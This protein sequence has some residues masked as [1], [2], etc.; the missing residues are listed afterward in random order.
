MSQRWLPVAV[1][2]AGLFAANLTA[3]LVVRLGY[4]DD[5]L[6]AD[7]ATLAMLAV[8]AVVAAGWAGVGATRHPVGRWAGDLA[9]GSLVGLLLSVFVGPFV[10]DV[11]PFAFGAGEFFK[12]IWQW[13]GAT[14][15]GAAL[16]YG[17][18]TAAGRDLRSRLLAE[19]AGRRRGRR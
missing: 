16:G 3:R 19:Q 11:T 15:V 18:V 5:A 9:V 8:V 7:G 17:A 2:A 6:V 12:Q 10:S 14:I 1:L 4:P 13:A